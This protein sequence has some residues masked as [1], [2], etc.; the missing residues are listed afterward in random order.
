M[1]SQSHQVEFDCHL[2]RDQF[3]SPP[4]PP[5]LELV[6]PKNP[7]ILVIDDDPDLRLGLHIRLRANSFDTC[8]AGDAE[9]AINVAIRQTPDLI[10]LDLGLPD[11]DGYSVMERL[12]V[13]P[14]LAGVPI[15]VITGRDRYT[16]EARV[17]DAGVKQFFAKPVDNLRLL[18]GIRQ[19]LNIGS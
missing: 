7:K 8:F 12:K 1:S 18:A 5:R 4:S 11:D 10:I 6:Q 3:V 17:R 13:L 19:L 15:I 14:D 16:H 2:N 9:S